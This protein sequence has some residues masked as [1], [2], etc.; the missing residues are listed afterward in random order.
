VVAV[1]LLLAQAAAVHVVTYHGH[2]DTLDLREE[3]RLTT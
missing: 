1:E 3:V 2:E